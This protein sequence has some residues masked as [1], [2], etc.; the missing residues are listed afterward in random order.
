MYIKRNIAIS[1]SGLVFNPS[2]GDSFSVNHIGQV[3]ISLLK[4]GIT[5][6]EMKMK[7]IERYDVSSEQVEEDLDDFI[8]HL[9]QLNIINNE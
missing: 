7:L 3:I 2:T 6:E 9:K 5:Q 8:N 4:S 1:E